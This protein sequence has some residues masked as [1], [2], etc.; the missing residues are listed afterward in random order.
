MGGKCFGVKESYES[1]IPFPKF[2]YLTS[3][4]AMKI[5]FI[6][7][8]EMK[9]TKIPLQPDKRLPANA[10]VCKT[11][12]SNFIIVGGLS[13]YRWSQC[14]SVYELD[15]ESIKITPKA[16][17]PF[18]PI[19]GSLHKHNRQVYLI[20]SSSDMNFRNDGELENEPYPFKKIKTSSAYHGYK[21][22]KPALFY[23]YSLVRD[24]WKEV[25]ITEHFW[26][27]D[28]PD[29]IKV[30]PNQ[31]LLPGT[32]KVNEKILFFSGLTEKDQKWQANENIYWFSLET[33]KI[34]V[35]ATKFIFGGLTEMR[36]AR[37]TKNRILILGGF[38]SESNYNSMIFEYVMDSGIRRFNGNIEQDRFFCDN[39][40][41]VG[42]YRY[43]VFFGYPSALLIRCKD[44]KLEYLNLRCE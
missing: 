1:Q 39:N 10:L 29:E 16:E 9:A 42:K 30:I 27:G 5:K 7:P 2:T 21:A 25:I 15:F 17:C 19:G 34:G 18:I 43:G 14:S 22:L 31:L 26:E 13:L 38:D 20:G 8:S 41:P 11:S 44:E 28:I 24:R 12:S 32:C 4:A 23:R 37:V 40:L 33:R 3:E 36:C 35:M 6:S